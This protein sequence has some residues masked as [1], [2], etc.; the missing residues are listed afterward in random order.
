[1]TALR[2]PNLISRREMWALSIS[3][4]QIGLLIFGEGVVPLAGTG[5]NVSMGIS[6]ISEQ[7]F[8]TGFSKILTGAI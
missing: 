6:V 3:I 2:L 1:M 8:S 5:N 4:L 7:R